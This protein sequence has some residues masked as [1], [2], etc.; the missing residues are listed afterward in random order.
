MSVFYVKCISPSRI[1]AGNK[2]ILW[3]W[4]L[5]TGQRPEVWLLQLA[6]RHS[7]HKRW[8]QGVKTAS[9]KASRHI[10]HSPCSPLRNSSTT[11]WIKAREGI[12]FTS[13][14]S[15]SGLPLRKRLASLFRSEN[16]WVSPRLHIPSQQKN[17]CHKV[18]EG[19]GKHAH[20]Y[21]WNEQKLCELCII[22]LN[23]KLLLSIVYSYS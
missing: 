22:K 16:S 2:Q 19:K 12:F 15:V 13:L 9:S 4:Y 21:A 1:I 10:G 5:Q 18:L 11:S 6:N 7:R 23:M 17:Y 3:R 20:I 14:S 8:A